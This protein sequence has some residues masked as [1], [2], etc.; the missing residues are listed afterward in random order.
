MNEITEF[1]KASVEWLG[2]KSYTLLSGMKHYLVNGHTTK[3]QPDINTDQQ[4]MIEN[5]LIRQGHTV[6]YR[7]KRDYKRWFIDS[8]GGTDPDSK[9]TA[10]RLAWMEFYKSLKKQTS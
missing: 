7:G 5:E 6:D 10:F 9:S 3:W 1:R 4:N 8:S 2:L